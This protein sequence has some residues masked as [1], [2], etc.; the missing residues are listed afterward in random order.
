MRT[1]STA[2]ISEKTSGLP[3]FMLQDLKGKPFK[4]G[5]YKC[6]NLLKIKHTLYAIQSGVHHVTILHAHW[7]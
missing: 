1:A 3:I 4:L 6:K 2:T 5:E 7:P